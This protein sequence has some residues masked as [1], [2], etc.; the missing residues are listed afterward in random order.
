MIEEAGLYKFTI[1]LLNIEEPDDIMIFGM[2]N[3]VLY[4]GHINKD[5]DTI[6]FNYHNWIY[7][8]TQPSWLKKKDIEF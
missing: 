5:K 8:H 4:Y 3:C 6:T 7:R 1:K 2:K